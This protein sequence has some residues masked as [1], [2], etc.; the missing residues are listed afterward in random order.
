MFLLTADCFQNIFL[1]KKSGISSECQTHC[2]Q[3]RPYVLLGLLWVQNV[4]KSY[5]QTTLGDKELNKLSS[6]KCNELI[7]QIVD[8]LL[9]K[10][11]KFLDNSYGIV[12]RDS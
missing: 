10:W 2:I 11:F 4:C 12:V 9:G 7:L 1:K 3:I 6:Y 8:Y 5:Q